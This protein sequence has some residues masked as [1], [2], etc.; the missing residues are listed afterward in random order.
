MVERDI[1]K[2][3]TDRIVSSLEQGVMPWRRPWRNAESGIGL[4]RNAVTDRTY[5]GGNRLILLATALDAGYRDNRWL[6][7]NQ[8]K[9]LG[10]SV[11]KGEHGTQIEYWEQIP[12]WR[13]KGVEYEYMD[14]PVRLGLPP[15]NNRPEKVM[16]DDGREVPTKELTVVHDGKRYTWRQAEQ[17]ISAL[18]NKAHVVFNVEQCKGLEIETALLP[19][20]HDYGKAEQIVRGMERD[21]VEILHGGNDA[22]YVAARDRVVMPEAR[23]FECHEAYL[24]TLLHE[25]GHATG[26][27]GRNNRPLGGVFGSQEYAREELI[28]EI[29]SAFVAA[30]TGIGF[31]DA[32]HAA[33]IGSWIQVLKSDKHEVFRAAKSASQAA[34][35]LIERGREI[36]HEML[37][38]RWQE[39]NLAL[40]AQPSR[41]SP[42]EVAMER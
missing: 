42:K 29:T 18:V 24:G 21:G 12:F 3:I 15:A 39:K 16:L 19:A 40:A 10:G 1:R 34:D 35:Y 17:M 23:R 37:Q 22:Y 6:T 11:M 9:T 41:T 25:L 38:G 5:N 28:A 2:E 20:I 26:H 31:E 14:K 32:N 27:P 30:E 8:A 36:E 33:Y 4:P 13:R 7:F